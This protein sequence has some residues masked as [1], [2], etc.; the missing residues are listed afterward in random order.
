MELER[1]GLDEKDA[2]PTTPVI[3]QSFSREAL[4]MVRLRLRS[5]LPLV[6]LIGGAAEADQWLNSDGLRR[7]KVFAT[8]I[9]PS[10]GLILDR[11]EIVRLAHAAGLTVTPYTFRA[12]APESFTTVT[13]EMAHY[14]FTLGVDGLFTNNPDLFPRSR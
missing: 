8:G 5:D 10:K 4:E 3:I 12:D 6:F 14:L 9:G 13:D 7:M 2:D 1:L 11:P